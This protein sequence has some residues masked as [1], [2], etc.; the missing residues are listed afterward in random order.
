MYNTI[1]IIIPVYNEGENI[2]HTLAEIEQKVS[3]PYRVFIIYDRDDDNTIAAVNEYM[4][5]AENI[6]LVKNKYGIGVLNAIK[7]GFEAVDEG[8]AVVVMA[9]LSDEIS[10]IDEMFTK[11]S[12]G[13]DIVCGSRYIRGGEQIG[14]PGF[15][16]MLSRMAGISL[17]YIT[18]IPTHDVSNSFK[19]YTKKVLNDIEIE[20]H[21]GFEIGMEITVKSFFKGYKIT[22]I[23][24]VWRDRSAGESKFRLWKWLPEYMHWYLFAVKQKV[25][26]LFK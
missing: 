12:R 4:R 15:K 5:S 19:M 26:S 8:V 2:K 23:P 14:G 22:E 17:H 21:G 20:S 10:K 6:T 16:K 24:T 11:I 3:G 25:H 7:T 18:G 1:N 13:Y 9:D